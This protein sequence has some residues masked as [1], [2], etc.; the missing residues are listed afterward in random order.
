MKGVK[1]VKALWLVLAISIV[2]FII[3]MALVVG[4]SSALSQ[5]SQTST[6]FSSASKPF[7]G[8]DGTQGNPY[9]IATPQ[10]FNNIRD[11]IYHRDETGVFDTQQPNYFLQIDDLNFAL[12]DLNGSAS[13]NINPI[14]EQNAF[15][16]VYDGGGYTIE[17]V[18]I[19]S[20]ASAVGLFGQTTASAQIYNFGLKNSSI[21]S[22]GSGAVG[23]I[24][25]NNLGLI[26]YVYSDAKVS[27]SASVGGLVGSN[28]GQIISSFNNGTLS[29]SQ[30]GG[31]AGV[32]SGTINGTYNSGAGAAG[33]IVYSQTGGSVAN[34]IYLN[35]SSSASVSGSVDASVLQATQA[36]LA[37][38]EKMTIQ[39]KQQFAVAALNAAE[40]NQVPA[41]FYSRNAE[42]S[43]PQLYMNTYDASLSLSGDGTAS[44]PYSVASPQALAIIGRPQQIS[45]LTT[46]DLSLG[47]DYVQ[48]FD[49]C[50]E[51]VDTNLASPG[52][53]T[54]VGLDESNGQVV[55]F[56]GTYYGKSASGKANLTGLEIATSHTNIALFAALGTGSV[57]DGLQISNSTITTTTTLPFQMAAFAA[58]NNGTISNCVNAMDITFAMSDSHNNGT[59]AAG[60]VATNNGRILLCANLGTINVSNTS[61]AASTGASSFVAGMSA[62]SN[63]SIERSYNAGNIHGGQTAGL[64][65]VGGASSLVSHCFNLGEITCTLAPWSAGLVCNA[66]G[67]TMSYCYNVGRATYGIAFYAPSS[68]THV[69]YLNAV[70]NQN[71]YNGNSTDNRIT[72][73]Q[74]AGMVPLSGS[75][76]FLDVFNAGGTFWEYDRVYAGIDGLPYQFAHLIDNKCEKTCAIA[77]Q[78]SVDGYHLVDSLEKFNGISTSSYNNIY[79]GGDG[80]FRLM[81]DLDYNRARY[82]VK[83]SFSGIFDGNGHSITDANPTNDRYNQLGM[84]NIISGNAIIKN[85]TLYECGVTNNKGNN[86]GDISSD[87]EDASA[88]I[89]AG[90][91]GLGVI[92][93]NV[94]I[95]TGYASCLNNTG[96]FVGSITNVDSATG[97]YIRG[98]SAENVAVSWIRKGSDPNR[99][100]GGFV[101]WCN[102]GQISSCYFAHDDT[103][104]ANGS[105]AVYGNWMAGG[106]VGVTGGSSNISNCFA[107]GSVYSDRRTSSGG[108]DDR[109]SVGGFIGLNDSSSTTISNCYAYVV[110]GGYAYDTYNLASTRRLYVKT[111]GFGHNKASG[112]FSNNYCYNGSN[113]LEN[114][115]ATELSADQMRSQGSF[116][117]WDFTNTWQMSGSGSL[118]YGMPIPRATQQTVAQTGNITITTDGNVTAQAYANGALVATA[119]SSSSG[120]LQFTGI[121]PGTYTIVL[122]R[123]GQTLSNASNFTSAADRGLE[124]LSATLNQGQANL[125]IA[126]QKYFASGSGLQ[127]NPYIVGSL[128][129]FLNIEKF[130]GQGDDTYFK[131]HSNIDANGQVL[132]STI[133]N[134]M[135]NFDGAGYQISN[136]EISKSS[137]A[138]ALFEQATNATIQNL[139]VSGFTITSSGSDSFTGGLVG[140]ASSTQIISSY[141]DNGILNVYANAGSLVGQLNGGSIKFSYATNN[142]TSLISGQENFTANLGG[143]VGQATGGSVIDQCYS[144]GNVVGTKLLGGFVA[145]ADNVAISNSYTTVQTLTDYAGQQQSQVGGFAGY[146]GVSSSITNSFMYGTVLNMIRQLMIGSFIGENNSQSIT[147]CYYWEINNF[148]AIYQNNT[149]A[150]VTSLSTVEFNQASSFDG[151][152]FIDV[153]GMPSVDSQASGSPI[154]RNVVNAFKVNEEILGDGTQFNP[155][156]IFDATT[157]AD[158]MTYHNNF[159]G[160]G[161]VY[162]KLQKDVDL[163][164]VNWTALGTSDAPF[165]GVLQGN[166]KTISGLM[167]NGSA[168][169]AYGLFAYT[170]GAVFEDLII[171]GFNITNSSAQDV[172]TLVGNASNTTFTNV[173]VQNNIISSQGN[174]GAVAGSIT[175][176]SIAD[177]T[178]SGNQIS[179]AAS[180]GG[181]VGLASQGEVFASTLSG[182]TIS[183][184]NVGGAIGSAQNSS[185]SAVLSTSNTVSGTNAGGIVG[186]AS[187]SKVSS[188][189]INNLTLQSAVYAGGVAG[190]ITNGSQIVGA[191]VYLSATMSSSQAAGGVVGRGEASQISNASINSNWSVA[192]TISSANVGGV[193]GNAVNMTLISGNKI[194]MLTLSPNSAGSVGQIY[195]L[196]EGSSGASSNLYRLVTIDNQHGA[197]V[198][199]MTGSTISEPV[200]EGTATSTVEWILVN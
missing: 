58:T 134:F 131:L 10:H 133:T 190:L 187:A 61:T 88:G 25:G 106:F 189:L 46:I 50:F 146:V 194:A 1:A 41:Y 175:G 4:V 182:N 119:T 185:I 102:G 130:S 74:L 17:N 162:F 158:L 138:A 11:F 132:S 78:I 69:Y 151:F 86:L 67:F 116:S 98:C 85:L 9:L 5:K 8:G 199:N 44:S 39:G 71:I 43:Y 45:P 6:T 153:W 13:G 56:S 149:S 55:Q 173:T 122:H 188:V 120:S 66:D 135:G 95:R 148:P 152:D 112:T 62:A 174:A 81:A 96:G 143:F 186:N 171:S 99:P 166:G 101:G 3:G 31:I 16:G 150:Q 110:I 193:I 179:S 145:Y 2:M 161:Q 198:N 137:G 125:T 114:A 73:N 22:T 82:P 49:I 126:S 128:Q 54:P 68:Q 29:G 92:I 70:A 168:S 80:R 165:T 24:V 136:F 157:F 63:G 107:Y 64:A 40:Q 147:N 183:G 26:K 111:R 47:A 115:G 105:V 87:Y 200:Y 75:Q 60:I 180:A 104:P 163:S 51:D 177:S 191:N 164:T 170:N 42:F 38:Q 167:F 21:T 144:D 196:L 124:V 140:V 181:A 103:S 184:A 28:G 91:V 83:E 142:L 178:I 127:S 65:V 14:G 176:G 129:Q 94:H 53:F 97:G 37:C 27:G 30:T 139:G 72:V 77:M 23:A 169:T 84:F 117:G 19:S 172:G 36:Q 155:Y 118:P 7:A 34:S 18:Q 57:L 141:A 197:A 35:S 76:Y 192:G 12:Y 160:E 154:L 100:T 15:A 159:A 32:N 52:N 121:A 113:D 156:I 79:Y 20:S 109:D 90:R 108:D 195:G 89:L 123:N 59:N 93:E 48:P 33:G